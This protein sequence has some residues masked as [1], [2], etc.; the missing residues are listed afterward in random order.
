MIRVGRA[1]CALVPL[2]IAFAG[3]VAKAESLQI[4]HGQR[5]AGLWCF[6]LADRSHEWKYLPSTAKLATDAS[7]KPEF[8]FIRYVKGDPNGGTA[9]PQT[10]T[11]A[12]GG[13]VLHMLALYETD[14][15]QVQEAQ[16]ELQRAIK[17][18]DLK[19]VGPVVFES[20][21][22]FVISSILPTTPDADTTASPVRHFLN[23]G[24]APVLEGNRIALSFALDKTQSGLLNQSFK[25]A[26]PDV[27]LVF[28]ME[29]SGLADPYDAT[30]T[31]DWSE[32]QKSEKFSAGG[33]IWFI[34]ADV[35]VAIDDLIRNGAIKVTSSGEN[36]TMEGL[37]NTA[38]A[39]IVDLLFAPKRDDQPAPA[40]TNPL[41]TL[42][43]A[44]GLGA[45]GQGGASWF[46]LY[47]SY[48][49]KDLHSSGRTV[50]SLNHQ[51]LVHR[52]TLL[53]VNVGPLYTKFGK[54]DAYF[55]VVNVMEDP[56]FQKRTISVSVDGSLLPEFQKYV[57]SVTVSLRKTHPDGTVT[58]GETVITKNTAATAVASAAGGNLGLTYGY[59]QDTDREAW[60]KYEYRTRWNFQG[61]G[62]YD[63]PWV[64]TD[65]P[66]I[67]VFAPYER[68][69]VK[70]VGDPGQ[71]KAHGV[72]YVSVR[73]SYPFFGS[74]KSQQATF[75]VGTE[76]IDS[77]MEVTLP[78][79]QFTTTVKTTWHFAG[80][81]ETV[82]T[83]DDSSGLLLLDELPSS[84]ASPGGEQ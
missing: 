41:D 79:N 78:A 65:N 5:A 84:P 7:N 26:N 24:A 12:E 83:R 76:L 42:L 8:S 62:S 69:I 36:A 33:K 66:M 58:L 14:P 39:K 43:T 81:H 9:D 20:G 1:L 15:H 67:T 19:L 44:V 50:I 28:D 37:L 47:G 16:A 10:I 46:N 13:G 22:Y 18:N 34:G 54:N 72:V 2:L 77:S 63:T 57:D 82:T 49:L 60:L 40:N 35:K 30:I 23:S 55:S 25:M 45:S 32:V 38:Y 74:E 52:H 71:L 11:E 3:S 6:P 21:R 73:V 29:F 61:G 53:T 68:R 51:N 75:R 80:D 17:D 27:S 59:A 70:I 31:V 64:T 56:V 48:Q 4:D